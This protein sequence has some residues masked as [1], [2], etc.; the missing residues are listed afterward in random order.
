MSGKRE[1]EFWDG[2]NSE[3]L[4]W[5]AT[6]SIFL[7]LDI[8]TFFFRIQNNK[9]WF[10]FFFFTS[11]KSEWNYC[12]FCAKPGE[13]YIYS[14]LDVDMLIKI[15]IISTT[16]RSCRSDSSSSLQ[17]IL[18]V[19]DKHEKNPCVYLK[20]CPCLWLSEHWIPVLSLIFEC[21]NLYSDCFTHFY[22]F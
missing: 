5:S 8:S 6:T 4:I 12:I 13:G 7:V 11:S 14:A 2:V 10:C 20:T 21:H 9:V 17:C 18:L 16:S 19:F 15:L 3:S 1:I 22:Q